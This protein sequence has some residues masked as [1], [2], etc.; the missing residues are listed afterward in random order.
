MRNYI[1]VCLLQFF[2]VLAFS[3]ERGFRL[4]PE[5]GLSIP[6]GDSYIENI[7]AKEGYQFGLN[8][9][10]MWGQFGLGLYGGLD[11][12][13]IEYHDFL[14]PSNPDLSVSR[15]SDIAQSYFQQFQFGLGPIFHL[16]FSKKFRIRLTK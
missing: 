13:G 10:K 3:Q 7:S 1:S 15:S 14:P 4:L 6:N 9:E 12:N 8:A 16:N 5:A 11:K 2:S